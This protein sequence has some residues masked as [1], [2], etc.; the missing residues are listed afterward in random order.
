MII[1][2]EL[3]D[4]PQTHQR[5]SGGVSLIGV[6]ENITRVSSYASNLLLADRQDPSTDLFVGKEL[7]TKEG[8]LNKGTLDLLTRS[9]KEVGKLRGKSTFATRGLERRTGLITTEGRKIMTLQYSSEGL[10]AIGV[11]L[12]ATE[13]LINHVVSHANDTLLV[14]IS[15]NGRLK[16]TVTQVIV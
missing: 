9:M 16:Q 2:S 8:I 4:R 6:V 10:L 14:Q 11:Q 1:S 12:S 13:E 15:H 7:L 5:H 3:L